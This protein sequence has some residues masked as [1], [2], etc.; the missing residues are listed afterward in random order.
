[1]INIKSHYQKKNITDLVELDNNEYI[2]SFKYDDMIQF[3]NKKSKKITKTIKCEKC[4]FSSSKNNMLLMNK[5]DLFL[6]GSQDILILDIQNKIIIK[7]IKIEFSGYLTSIYKLSDNILLA[8][9][10]N[11]YI[12]QLEYDEIKKEFKVISKT[13]K[14]K[15][16][17]YELYEASSIAILKNNL[18]VAPFDNDLNGSSLIIYK[19]KYD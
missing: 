12:E 4:F 17:N 11:N 1:M 19:Y 13:S 16:K 8:G 9:Y 10:W 2:I 15:N 6:L 7:K 18:I 5:N 3:L 14:K